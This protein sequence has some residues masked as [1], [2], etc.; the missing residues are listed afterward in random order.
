MKRMVSQIFPTEVEC[1]WTSSRK[2]PRRVQSPITTHG[3]GAHLKHKELV[4]TTGKVKRGCTGGGKGEFLR[5]RMN[6]VEEEG[7]KGKREIQAD[8]Q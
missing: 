4:G 1:S 5:W 3:L 8:N 2:F 6:R 7:E